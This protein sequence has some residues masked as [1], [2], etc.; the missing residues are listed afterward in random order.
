MTGSVASLAARAFYWLVLTAVVVFLLAPAL[1]TVV[2][3]L[4][5]DLAIQFP[6]QSWGLR[7]YRT[8]LAS[9][10]WGEAV[11]LSIWLG[12]VVGAL[13]VLVAVPAVFALNRTKL[14][15]ARTLEFLGIV[16]LL[17]PQTAYAIG[18]YIIVAGVGLLGTPAGLVAAHTAICFPLVFIITRANIGRLSSDLELVAMTLGATR[19]RAWVGVTLRL[20]LPAVA[21]GFL[22]AFLTSFDEAVFASFLTGPGLVTLPKAIFDSVRLGIDPVITAIAT[23]LIAFTATIMGVNYLIRG[24]MSE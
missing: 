21:S 8:L 10:D 13:S 22:F 15:G 18:M 12:V 7:Q 4:S 5:N 16:P 11:T 9:P 1:L 20:L 2:L 24:R 17:I 14:P 6:P 19:W 3:S 23:L